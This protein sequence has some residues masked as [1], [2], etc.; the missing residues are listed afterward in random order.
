M[1]ARSLL[2]AV[3]GGEAVGPVRLVETSCV[4]F[5]SATGCWSPEANFGRGG[6]APL[7]DVPEPGRGPGLGTSADEFLVLGR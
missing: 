1:F 2:L 7:L 4:M 5:D 6:F 3:V